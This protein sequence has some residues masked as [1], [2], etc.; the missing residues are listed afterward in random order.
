V[1]CSGGLKSLWRS[2]EGRHIQKRGGNSLAGRRKQKVWRRL[3]G[4]ESERYPSPQLGAINDAYNKSIANRQNLR[5]K[6]GIIP[7]EYRGQPIEGGQ[8]FKVKAGDWLLIPPDTPHQPK[9]DP[10]GFSYRIMKINVGSYP[11]ALIR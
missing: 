10:A 9:P 7:C 4:H 2:N 11:W 6:D 5:D 8:T 3:N 1:R